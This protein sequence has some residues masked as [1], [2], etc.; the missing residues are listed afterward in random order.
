MTKSI[1]RLFLVGA[2]TAII[3]IGFIPLASA[4]TYDV[5]TVSNFDVSG[6]GVTPPGVP[7]SCEGLSFY[8]TN[9]APSSGKTFALFVFGDNETSLSNLANS[10]NRV[11]NSANSNL[12]VYT[13]SSFDNILLT[14]VASTG[15]GNNQT[16]CFNLSEC[17]HR[18]VATI[19]NRL[20]ASNVEPVVIPPVV[21]KN[22]SKFIYTDYTSRTICNSAYFPSYTLAINPDTTKTLSQSCIQKV[23]DY[24]TYKTVVSETCSS[25]YVAPIILNDSC[26][27]DILA[28]TSWVRCLFV[29]TEKNFADIKVAYSEFLTEGA[30]G[31]IIGAGQ[32]IISPIGQ[33]LWRGTND[34]Q[35]RTCLGVRINFLYTVPGSS[36]YIQYA[37]NPFENCDGFKKNIA[38]TY[39]M[40]IQ[41]VTITIAAFIAFSNLILNGLNLGDSLFTRGESVDKTTGEIRTGW[42]RK[43]K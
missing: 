5:T 7:G 12:P 36:A 34:A 11:F 20:F 21:V 39:A 43:R 38:E 15:S 8:L 3:S 23:N 40:P 9:P 37:G 27:F 33:V 2:I 26:D 32:N 13:C 41:Y 24:T 10:F 16:V 18:D 19:G 4:V 31:Q 30:L 14:E 6:V 1:K 42:R 17:A 35:S 22:C 28:P 25:P 29:P